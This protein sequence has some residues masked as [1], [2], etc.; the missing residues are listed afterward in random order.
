M[1]KKM[2]DKKKLQVFLLATDPEINKNRQ[3][4][5]QEIAQL[6]GVAQSTIAASVK[7]V[8]ILK[9]AGRITETQLTE[10]RKEALELLQGSGVPPVCRILNEM[11]GE[12]VRDFAHPAEVDL[13]GLSA[14]EKLQV[15]T[16]RKL[17]KVG[18][19]QQNTENPFCP[20]FVMAG[21]KATIDLTDIDLT[22]LQSIDVKRLNHGIG[23]RITDALWCGM[24]DYQAAVNAISIYTM[25]YRETFDET[26]WTTCVMFARRAIN[27]ALQMG[28]GAVGQK[29]SPCHLILKDLVRVD[30]T[31]PLFLSISLIELLLKADYRQGGDFEK[32]VPDILIRIAEKILSS[33]LVSQAP[34]IDLNKADQAD[35]LLVSLIKWKYGRDHVGCS[36]ALWDLQR[37]TAD[38]YESIAD[39]SEKKDFRDIVIADSLYDK[40]LK[41]RSE[42][43]VPS[44]EARGNKEHC[45]LIRKKKEALEKEIPL[46]MSPIQVEATINA[47]ALRDYLDRNFD[48]L[49]FREWIVR[50]CQFTP[51]FKE[52]QIREETVHEAQTFLFPTLATESIVNSKG[53]T[54]ALL[55]P[56]DAANP[57]AD[58]EL[59]KLHM[60]RQLLA[61]ADLTGGLTL[62]YILQKFRD[63]FRDFQKEELKFLVDGN[64]IIPNGRESIILSG[65]YLGLKGEYFE[66][67]HILAPQTE[68][69]FRHIA[70]ASGGLTVHYDQG[71]AE[72]KTLTSIFDLP[73]LKDRND[74]DI[75]FLFRGLLNEKAGLNMRNNIAHGLLEEDE[76]KGGASIY[77][78]C[79]VMKLLSYKSAECL[80][81][82]KECKRL[83]EFAEMP[84]DAII[85]E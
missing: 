25:L 23:A 80:K 38:L 5:Q 76:A 67:L 8:S 12:Q 54:V 19:V 79:A 55:P 18:F 35:R 72:A 65:I 62:S 40:A 21:G 44:E 17:G 58:E 4:T 33:A 2:T 10:A 20:M 41:L 63:S 36:A 16:V 45:D 52:K 29:E 78:I 50:I 28:K 24:K 34:A 3:H 53:Q 61:S 22:P 59:L 46:N 68:A 31:D 48:G 37:N 84:E 11:Y 49:S 75:L 1:Q 74:N 7:Q 9:S 85:Q 42:T 77:F 27:I 47:K 82:L 26:Q 64:P 57:E 13:S 83:R 56:L 69:I 70:E 6:F 51:F 15:E 30:G 43:N 66:S 39:K 32:P 14:K 71:I 60:Y 73:E 81:I